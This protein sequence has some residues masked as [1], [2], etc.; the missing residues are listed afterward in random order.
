MKKQKINEKEVKNIIIEDDEDNEIFELEQNLSSNEIMKK[1]EQNKQIEKKMKELEKEKEEIE[2]ELNKGNK[3]KELY[4]YF[5]KERNEFVFDINYDD[6]NFY[7]TSAKNYLTAI[8]KNMGK[9]QEK[10]IKIIGYKVL[11]NYLWF[12]INNKI[13]L[14]WI[15]RKVEG[16]GNY[17]G[18]SITQLRPS[19]FFEDI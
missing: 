11:N 14:K 15:N 10:E 8:M 16:K 1:Q 3:M 5:R 2:K 9:Q 12:K 17:P 6:G 19:N 4:E 13:I 18:L 7:E